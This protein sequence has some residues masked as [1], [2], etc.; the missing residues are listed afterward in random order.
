MSVLTDVLIRRG[1]FGHRDAQKEHNVVMKA[2]P[3]VVQ[4]QAKECK[5]LPATPPESRR[6]AQIIYSSR[7]SRRN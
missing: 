3:R 2:E 7:A 1:N 6:E 4:L 5:G